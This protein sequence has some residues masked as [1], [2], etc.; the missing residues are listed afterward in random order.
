MVNNHTHAV[1]HAYYET[2]IYAVFKAS[3]REIKIEV[4][5]QL[6][7]I[8]YVTI[9]VLMVSTF[10]Q[11]IFG[12]QVR[13]VI[14]VLK[15]LSD[16]PPRETW[17]SRVGLIDEVHRTFSW[18]VLA[19]GGVL[20]YITKWRAESTLLKRM[21]IAVLGLIGLQIV[22]GIGLYYLGLPPAYQVFHLVGIAFLI[23]VEFLLFLLVVNSEEKLPNI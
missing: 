9:I 7:W 23:A 21:G 8:L 3:V 10:I 6:S 17:I 4:S 16:P 18:V 15:N 5:S 13:E 19:A 1:G 22:T 12:T 2:L 20:F 14:D 11:L